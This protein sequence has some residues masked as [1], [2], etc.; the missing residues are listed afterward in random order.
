MRARRGRTGR[1][2]ARTWSDARA[3]SPRDQARAR[4]RV[5][6]GE[7]SA[8]NGGRKSDSSAG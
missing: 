1:A 3:H 8:V 5:G 6:V 7:V 4:T 2:G